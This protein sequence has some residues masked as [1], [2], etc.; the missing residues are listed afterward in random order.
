MAGGVVAARERTSEGAQIRHALLSAL[1]LT[2]P[3]RPSGAGV[4]DLLDA[5]AA[6]WST[7]RLAHGGGR[8]LP[9]PPE[10]VRGQPQAIWS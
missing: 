9:D 10:M 3:E 8:S 1:G 2:A 5:C 6:A 7:G 4:D